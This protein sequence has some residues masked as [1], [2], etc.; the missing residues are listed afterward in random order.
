MVQLQL[1]ADAEEVQRGREEARS[2][3][4]RGA[5]HGAVPLGIARAGR[6]LLLLLGCVCVGRFTTG[7]G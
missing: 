4:R 5:G 1:A 2:G 7:F 3:A 6:C